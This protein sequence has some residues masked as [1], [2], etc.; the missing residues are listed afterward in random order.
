MKH[1]IITPKLAAILSCAFIMTSQSPLTLAHAST[2]TT[3]LVKG[4]TLLGCIAKQGEMAPEFKA[5]TEDGADISL[6]DL[7]GRTVILSIFPSINTGVC[8]VQTRKFNEKAAK[9]GEGVVVASV[10]RNTGEDFK[11]FCATAGIDRLLNISDL[12]YGEFGEK[13]GFRMAGSDYLARGIIVVDPEGKMSYVEYTESLGKE[14]NYDAALAA[15]IQS[16][17]TD[18]FLLQPLPYAED[19]LAPH[20]SKET[21]SFHYG[22]HL[23]GYVKNLN[24]LVKGSELE[25]KSLEAIVKESEGA[26]FNNAGQIYN[27]RIYFDQFAPADKA[28]KAPTG[29]LLKAID[30]TWGSV[31][32]FKAAFEKAG[33]GQFGS[34]WVWLSVDSEGKLVIS[35]T[36]NADS[37][38]TKGMTPIIGIDV[39]EHAYYLDFQNNRAA[40]LKAA[41]NIMDWKKVEARYEK[42]LKG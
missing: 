14:P 26:V 12:A 23:A 31:D 9:L 35:T 21:I 20:I 42:A 10:A 19:A 34:G 38:L 2:E 18:L 6:S 7:R 37:P 39:W 13:Y 22:K 5:Q 11:K 27:H 24:K 33:L 8:Q 1:R 29:E 28:Q 30:A 40:S 32:A 3:G 36:A 15:A 16:A 41:W 17:G 25:G 4:A